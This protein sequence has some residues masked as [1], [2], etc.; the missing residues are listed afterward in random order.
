ML[1]GSSIPIKIIH[2]TSLE[3]L[4]VEQKFILNTVFGENHSWVA[5]TF[6]NVH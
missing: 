6:L 2:L 1:P 3:I 5:I 4:D